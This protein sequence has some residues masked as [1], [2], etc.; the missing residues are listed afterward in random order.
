MRLS[1]LMVKLISLGENVLSDRIRI[2]TEP[3]C[4]IGTQGNIELLCEK[5]T[6][7]SM[8]QTVRCGYSWGGMATSK[9]KRTV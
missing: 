6:Q 5:C 1:L 9:C 7:A 8:P 2:T 4:Y 3:P